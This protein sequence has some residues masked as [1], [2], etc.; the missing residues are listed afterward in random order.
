MTNIPGGGDSITRRRHRNA[1]LLALLVTIIWSSSWV[2]IKIGLENLP[3][4][5]F[6]GLRYGLATLC[7]LPFA[8]RK[9]NLA[10]I[11]QMRSQDW[12]GLGV[13]GILFYTIAQAGQYIALSFLP[14]VTVSLM[15]SL[16]AVVVVILGILFLKEMPSWLQW[17]GIAFFTAGLVVYF[18]P[19]SFSSASWIGLA[20][21]LAAT[22]STSISSIL[23]RYI[24][25]SKMLSPITVTVISMG[26]GSILMLVWG[27]ISEGVPVLGWV[28]WVMVI[29]MAVVNTAFAFTLWNLTLQTLTAMESSIINNTMLVQIAIL[30]WVFL[31]E[32]IDLKMGVGLVLVIL[33]VV[34]VQLRKDRKA[35]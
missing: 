14:A 31:G 12:V 16:T 21:A 3:P 25:R 1:G 30:A 29:W 6:A 24:N 32:S 4:V 28:E 2:M 9:K 35:G 34:L 20:F 13:L 5:G 19:I 23:G 17:L 8:L 26:I 10:V 22:L 33:G 27:W 11:K 18:Y 15:L 7:L